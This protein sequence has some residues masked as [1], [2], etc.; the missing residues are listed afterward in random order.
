[1]AS[2]QTPSNNPKKD[3]LIAS[4]FSPSLKSLLENETQKI[5]K[6]SAALYVLTQHMDEMDNLKRHIRQYTCDLLK[7]AH[8]PY[9]STD[10]ELE[11]RMSYIMSYIDAIMSFIE[12]AFA[13]GV[14]AEEN[15]QLLLRELRATSIHIFHKYQQLVESLES[16]ISDYNDTGVSA[17]DIQSI[18]SQRS[19]S[20]H[21][22]N[23]KEKRDTDTSA[24][25]VNNSSLRNNIHR[26][27]QGAKNTPTQNHDTVARSVSISQPLSPREER[28][29]LIMAIIKRKG[30]AAIRDIAIHIHTCSEKTLQRDIRDLINEGKVVKKGE[31]KWAT[32]Q[33]H[34]DH[35]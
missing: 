32:Y 33:I 8:V 35:K 28:K 17:I 12:L 31:R 7:M 11:F 20:N 18:L 26:D 10:E 4:S 25:S 19:S 22:Q 27:K 5:K 1:M 34:Q 9:N 14:I 21:N 24:S 29:E 3:N 23:Q 13:G 6:I 2:S 15:A 16:G 30:S